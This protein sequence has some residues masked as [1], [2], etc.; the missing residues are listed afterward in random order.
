MVPLPS[1][2]EAEEIVNR[3]DDIFSQIDALENWCSAELARSSTLRQSILKA[4]F[5][6][7]LVPRD[8]KDEPASKL[9]KRIQAERDKQSNPN[10]KGRKSK[11]TEAT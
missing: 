9:L 3:V 4:A 8:P 6:G 10:T 11:K 7:K 1:V 5:S 2:E